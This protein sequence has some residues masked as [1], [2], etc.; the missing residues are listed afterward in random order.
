MNSVAALLS[1][2]ALLLPALV[3]ERPAAP[4]PLA[5]GDDTIRAAPE[6]AAP[7][8]TSAATAPLRVLDEAR[9][10]PVQRQ[11]RIQER[12]I[13][14][15]APSRERALQQSMARLAAEADHF[16]ERNS[17]D[18]VP[19]GAI[20][21]VYP[22]RENRLL[23]LMRDRRVMSAALERSCNAAD[24]YAGFYVERSEDGQLCSR[25]DRLQSR[26]GASCRVTRL[27]RL[28]ASGD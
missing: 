22:S 11:V 4:E 15:I 28:V 25:R 19:I 2:L 1:P 5:G 26:A 14:R 21:G 27:S 12:V 3:T 13:I 10:T 24:Y 8:D 7:A 9:A 17:A 18:C 23:L 6:P 20:A 16:E